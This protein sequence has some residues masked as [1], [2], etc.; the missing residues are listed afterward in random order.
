[1]A[2]FPVC[3]IGVASFPLGLTPGVAAM[4]VMSRTTRATVGSTASDSPSLARAADV[5]SLA[6]WIASRVSVFVAA[7]YASWVFASPAGVFIGTGEQTGPSPSFIDSWNRWDVEWYQSISADGYGAAGH[8]NN[9]A[10]LPGLPGLVHA[11]DIGGVAPTIA[12]LLVSL[13]AGGFAAVALGRLTVDVGGRAEWGVIAWVLAPVA[14]FLA[15]PYTEALFCAFAFWAWVFARRG[16]WVPASVLVAA[17]A[18]VRV[19]ALFLAAALMVAFL[20]SQRRDW[21]Q[22]P[23][24]ALPWIATAAWMAYFHAITG[25]WRTWFDAESAGWNRHFGNPIDALMETYRNG[26]TNGVAAS[27]AVQYRIEIAAMGLLVLA[28]V[29][30]LIKRWWGEATYVLLTCVALGTS[31]LYYSVPRAAVVLC[32]V[33]MLLGLWMTRWRPVRWAYVAISAPLMLVAVIGFTQGRWVA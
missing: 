18:W 8:E 33:W 26:W 31:T 4:A 9:F 12:G 28:G 13:V 6:I 27:F 19:N 20:T 2:A 25:S 1:M 11:L 32:P 24:L 29:A 21:R 14:V 3:E 10:F 5:T 17:S 7:F 15:V 23:A 30:M 16:Q 22:A